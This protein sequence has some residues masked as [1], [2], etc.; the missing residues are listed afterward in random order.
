M[1]GPSI[2]ETLRGLWL[3]SYQ[4]GVLVLCT[5]GI[6]LVVLWGVGVL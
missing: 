2:K 6:M 5:V 1:W 4:T 3:D